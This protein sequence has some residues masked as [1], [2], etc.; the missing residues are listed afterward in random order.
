MA[1]FSPRDDMPYFAAN[2]MRTP[3]IDL[4]CRSA[5]LRIAK[6]VRRPGDPD[7]WDT[8]NSGLRHDMERLGKALRGSGEDA[9]ESAF[10]KLLEHQW[11]YE[12]EFE[13]RPRTNLPEL[14]PGAIYSALLNLRTVIWQGWE[15][16]AT[17]P[18]DLTDEFGMPI[19][20]S[21]VWVVSPKGTLRMFRG[22]SHAIVRDICFHMLAWNSRHRSLVDAI[23]GDPVAA[24][25]SH[26]PNR[27]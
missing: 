26:A 1:D 9:R 18:R 22:L 19:A 3:L 16:V 20:E 25:T 27:A 7:D 13:R 8:L 6:R 12:K 11:A 15:I 14:S 21:R 5:M 2:A 24:F 10:W 23:V 4:A 17:V